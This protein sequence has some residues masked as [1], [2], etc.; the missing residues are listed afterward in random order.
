MLC[1][2]L[3]SI[4][5]HVAA[6]QGELYMTQLSI[7]LNITLSLLSCFQFHSCIDTWRQKVSSMRANQRTFCCMS[8]RLIS[9]FFNSQFT[10][11]GLGQPYNEKSDVYSLSLLFW[12]ILIL[13]QPY[14]YFR[15]MGPF[16]EHVWGEGGSQVRP[17]IPPKVSKDIRSL[18]ERA[19]SA[20]QK[21]RP[22][23]LQ[24]EKTLR[25]ICLS[26]NS[27]MR[28]NHNTRR[29]TFVFVRGQGETVNK[30]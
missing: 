27:S 16:Q 17:A 4:S 12:E 1:P 11:V 30:R 9:H 5:R 7:L 10:I 22:T 6:R 15:G 8:G 21:T 18:L 3:P 25:Q 26:F 14:S 19:W 29:S 2:A 13:K 24:F 23:A 28:V 20:N